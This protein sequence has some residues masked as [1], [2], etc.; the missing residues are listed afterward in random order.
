M[1][2]KGDM[3][4]ARTAADTISTIRVIKRRQGNKALR[5]NE[6]SLSLIVVDV[7][8]KPHKCVGGRYHYRLVLLCS[9]ER[10]FERSC[11]SHC[12]LCVSASFP[13]STSKTSLS[14]PILLFT[15]YP[16]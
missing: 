5:S 13:T 12:L 10:K 1:A 3:K 4:S 16:L 2:T 6:E 8:K 9:P 7:T 15:H 11:P 14:P